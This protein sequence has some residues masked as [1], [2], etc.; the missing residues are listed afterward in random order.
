MT[1]LESIQ[2]KINQINEEYENEQNMYN[3]EDS[4]SQNLTFVSDF[5]NSIEENADSLYSLDDTKAISLMK[6]YMTDQVDFDSIEENLRIIKIVLKGKYSQQLPIDLS[7]D[8][9]NF[10]KSFITSMKIFDTY[11]ADIQQQKIQKQEE[12]EIKILEKFN[13]IDDLLRKITDP[14][15]KT[16]DQDDFKVFY[17]YII[18]DSDYSFEEKKEALLNFRKFNLGEDRGI[19]N[20]IES[21]KSLFKEFNINGMDKLIDKFKDEVS[22]NANLQNIREVLE[23]L[24]NYRLSENSNVSIINRFKP[25]KL[26]TV[27]LYGTKESIQEQLRKMKTGQAFYNILFERPSVWVTHG[28]RHRRRNNNL[29]SRNERN[30]STPS[31]RQA[32]YS[33][34]YEEMLENEKFLCDRGIKV[35]LQDGEGIC[36]I[37]T[38]YYIIKDNYAAAKEY[39]LLDYRD[40]E[41]SR[42]FAATALI[43]SNLADRCDRMIELGLLH[44]STNLYD[45]GNYAY[46]CPSVFYTFTEEKYMLL[47][48]LKSTNTIT[49]YYQR[50]FSRTCKL[51]HEFKHNNLNFALNTKE[52]IEMFEANNFIMPEQ[53]KENIPNFDLYEY[54]TSSMSY[55]NVNPEI[56]EDSKIKKLEEQFRVFGNDYVYQIDNQTISRY[57]V[58]RYYDALKK[59]GLENKDD[60]LLYCITKESYMNK[61]TFNNIKESITTQFVKER[62]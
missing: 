49:D 24:T 5:I 14:T 23:F 47:Y 16:L 41:N 57:K 21:I 34:S 48:Y 50:I 37:E 29:T 52:E 44:G 45:N 17:E 20:D 19:I 25:G 51:S 12:K 43:N 53:K 42:K 61:N 26:L 2:L 38:P 7:I 59:Q 15:T 60:A 3:N 33:I 32:A 8:Q 36:T 4:L 27:A 11:L 1:L 22:L 46:N 40:N 35:S 13:K 30:N 18:N 62:K 6:E 56:L 58:L 54:I 55:S 39:G 9:K 10:I 28:V 31:L